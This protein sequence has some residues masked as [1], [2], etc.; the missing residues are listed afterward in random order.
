MPRGQ[1]F[2]EKERRRFRQLVRLV[3]DHGIAGGQQLRHPLVLEH[4]V[5]EEQ[6]M[7]D[8]D[9][10]RGERLAPRS[11]HETV[12]KS[13]TRLPQ[14]VFPGRGREVPGR[15]LLGHIGKLA[16]VSG[17][18]NAREAHD[19]LQVPDDLATG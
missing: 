16:L 7:V 14:A 17:A 12:A 15:S 4:H 19:A 9:E 1:R 5:G 13:R 8:Y 10:V 2:A 3:E 11:H 18:G 6:M